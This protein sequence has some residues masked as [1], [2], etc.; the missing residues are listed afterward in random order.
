MRASRNVRLGSVVCTA[1]LLVLASS[2]AAVAAPK[3]PFSAEV[4]PHT[5]NTGSTTTY[6][7]KVTNE[8]LTQQLGS[9]NLTAPPGFTIVSDPTQPS[10]GTATRVGNLIKLRNLSTLPMQERSTSFDATAPSI[11][12]VYTWA[13]VCRQANNFTPD[14]PSNQFGLTGD[15]GNMKTTVKSPGPPPPD[16]DMGVT[17]NTDSLD[18]ITAANTVVYTVT[19]ESFG[20]SENTGLT[21]T[22]SLPNGGT[23][24]AASGENWFCGV[25]NNTATC[26]HAGVGTGPVEPVNVYVVAPDAATTIVNRASIAESGANDPNSANDSLDES[27]EVKAKTDCTEPGALNCGEGTI[28]FSLQSRVQTCTAPT[29]TEFICSAVNFAPTEDPGSQQYRIWSPSSPGVICPLT[30]GSEALTTCNWQT[31]MAPV[32]TLYAV[33]QVSGEFICDVTKCPPPAV[34]GT[35]TTI[36]VYVGDDG[37]PRNVPRCD[38]A[39]DTRLCFTSTRIAGQDLLI[40]VRNIVPGDPKI[41]GRCLGGC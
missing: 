2:F 5:V 8:A 13:I 33:G 35:G 25:A 30:P 24:S 37:N 40:T 16:A 23:M 34:P 18:P 32:S 7:L 29:T 26:T 15:P 21:L 20:P 4:T 11:E 6:T 22:D 14:A 19:V 3:K 38:G 10:T 12:G 31:N 27:T 9:C 39:G 28:T 36:V 17:D 1:F 41:A